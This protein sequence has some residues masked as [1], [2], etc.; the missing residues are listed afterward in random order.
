MKELWGSQPMNEALLCGDQ[1]ELPGGFVFRRLS[2]G[3]GWAPHDQRLEVVVLRYRSQ[4]V[5]F[6][7]GDTPRG[8][9]QHWLHGFK[10]AGGA[11]LRFSV[12]FADRWRWAALVMGVSLLLLALGW[13]VLLRDPVGASAIAVL[14][15]LGGAA[16]CGSVGL[17]IAAGWVRLYE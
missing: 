15:L 17:C 2:P 8:S 10:T 12:A 6:L 11:G 1:T 3:D 13:F 4:P 5:A 14:G 16:V 7:A 9:F